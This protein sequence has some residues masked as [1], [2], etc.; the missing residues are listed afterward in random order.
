MKRIATLVFLIS[1]VGHCFVSAQ[2]TQPPLSISEA[3]MVKPSD[4][5]LSVGLYGNIDYTQPIND[6]LRKTGKLDVTRMVLL[7]NYKFNNKLDFFGEIEFEHVKELWVEQAFLQYRINSLIQLRAGLMVIPM[8]I[9]NEYHEPTTHNGVKRPSIDTRIVPTTWREIGVGVT[10]NLNNA[11]LKYQLYVVNGFN[12][13]DGT[14]R[15]GGANGLRSGRQR[16]AESYISSPNLSARVDYYGLSG[17][18]L[19]FSGYFGKTQSVL[20]NNLPK[21]NDN[22]LKR[23]DSSVVNLSMIGVDARYSIG[24]FQLRGQYII[25]TIGNTA[26]YN[27]FTG[28]DLGSQMGGWYA[29]AGYDIFHRTSLSETPLIIFARFEK[30]NLH[31]KTEGNLNKNKAYNMTELTT[32]IG[33]K[34]AA[35][36][37]IK[38]DVQLTKAEG[39]DKYDI[40][41]NAG[42]GIIF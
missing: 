33:Y 13:Y 25:N 40:S 7:M 29:E 5:K 28:K 24:G 16:G 11:G 17:L 9:I 20:F 22:G 4:N 6:T 37:M 34:I 21:N 38:T 36:A 2:T 10:G 18:S 14:A 42:I 15:L 23:A 39:Q 35:G 31:A 3:F 26:S 27:Q 8:G 1:W 32:G 12:S 41:F 30:Y 19:G